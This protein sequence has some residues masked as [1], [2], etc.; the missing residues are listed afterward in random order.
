MEA[1]WS[2]HHL[3]GL[4]HGWLS[5]SLQE[6]GGGRMEHSRVSTGGVP[7]GRSR[8]AAAQAAVFHTTK[9]EALPWARRSAGRH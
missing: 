7:V 9:R 2:S 3:S 1:R 6:G 5:T 4:S 8:G